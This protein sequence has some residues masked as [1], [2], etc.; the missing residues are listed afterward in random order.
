MYHIMIYYRIYDRNSETCEYILKNRTKYTYTKMRANWEIHVSISI[1]DTYTSHGVYLIMCTS[2]LNCF[3]F[4]I[5]HARNLIY[6]ICN[7]KINFC[8]KK[9]SFLNFFLQREKWSNFS[10]LYNV[11]PYRHWLFLLTHVNLRLSHFKN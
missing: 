1:Q 2:Y 8:A 11:K 9:K 6:R 10:R 4:H 5:S 3:C 7:I